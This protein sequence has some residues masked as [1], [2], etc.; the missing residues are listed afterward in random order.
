[1]FTLCIYELFANAVSKGYVSAAILYVLSFIILNLLKNM[2][3]ND[4]NMIQVNHIQQVG[5]HNYLN[6]FMLKVFHHRFYLNI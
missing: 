1:M 2:G 5:Y 6:L 4:P 3:Y